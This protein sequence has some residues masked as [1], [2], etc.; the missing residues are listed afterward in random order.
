ASPDLLAAAAPALLAVVGAV[1]VAR[2]LPALVARLAPLAE[3]SR[4][5][6]G[7]L[8]VARARSDGLAAL[9]LLAVA[10]AAALVVVGASAA[11]AVRDGQ[12]AAAWATVGGDARVQGPPDA[13]LTAAAATWAEDPGVTAAVPARVVRDVPVRSADGSARVDVVVGEPAALARLASAL[14]GAAL[15]AAADP[16]AAA[17]D[18]PAGEVV[19]R[20]DGEDRTVHALADLAVPRPSA[21]QDGG[22]AVVVVDVAELGGPDAVPPS[23]VWLVGPGAEAAVRA[24]PPPGDAEVTVRVAVLGALRADVLPRALVGAAAV[25]VVLLLA[26]VALAVLVAAAAGGPARRRALDTLRTV[27]LTD[28][29]A[30]R[31]AAGEVLPAALLASAAGA[32]L[33]CAVTPV[34]L[35]PLGLAAASAPG[36]GGPVAWLAVALPVLAG[37]VAAAAVLRVEHARRRTHRLGEVLRAGG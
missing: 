35:G 33:G 27:G 21:G 19:I 15:P 36:T 5:A 13:G 25:S 10:T 3:R 23:T 31:V 16:A 8:A 11:V 18:A 2:V 12:D 34:V 28:R 7:V 17:G 9:P 24:T 29:E 22:R 26:F 4:R 37:V 6:V 20:W 14:P 30:R 32:A 1:V